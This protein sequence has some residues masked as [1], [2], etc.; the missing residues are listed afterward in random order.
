MPPTTSPSTKPRGYAHWRA[1]TL[2]GVHVLF[3]AHIVHWK[4]A[5]K[6]LA[7]LELNELMVTLELGVVTAGFAFMCLVFLSVLIFGRFFCS[8][9]CHI[10]A[11][12]D[13][14]QW[15]LDKLHIR[16]KPLRSR[17]LLWVPVGATL[18]MFLWPQ[19]SRLVAG[20]PLPDLRLHDEGQAWASF[21]TEDFWRNLPPVGMA[22]LTFF[23]VGFVVTLFLGSRSF[24]NYGCPYGALF[25]IAD[26]FTPGR[27]KRVSDCSSCGHCTAACS[28]GIEVHK[29]LERYGTV[30]SS[31]CL[32]D[33]DCIDACPS[34]AVGFGFTKP[35][36]FRK[37]DQGRP[38]KPAT[39]SWPEEFAG[40]AIF[41][42]G[43]FV[44]RGLYGRLPFLMSLSLGA[45]LAWFS[46][47]MWRMLREKH[48][49][50]GPWRLKKGGHW[51]RAG[52]FA[53]PIALLIWS[54][55][56]H[57]AWIRVLEVRAD[58][59]YEF[60]MEPELDATERILR[61]RSAAA[62]L[63]SLRATSPLPPRNTDRRI[64]LLHLTAA[65]PGGEV[66]LQR[67]VDANPDSAY[68]RLLLART[69]L[70]AGDDAAAR[71]ETERAIARGAF[72]HVEPTDG[73]TTDALLAELH[74]GCASDLIALERT[75][76]AL[77]HARAAV[78][79][80]PRNAA[81]RCETAS[82]LIATGQLE[83][84]IAELRTALEID[85]NYTLARERLSALGSP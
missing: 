48:A 11:L 43:L 67:A 63:R 33:L 22:L 83:A 41:L 61:A 27:I 6:T 12:Q 17:L 65:A 44:F 19:L 2:L 20:D 50:F 39:L 69:W 3:A 78:A 79:L 76:D 74:A 7:P 23:V 28:S 46:I 75:A 81:L 34:G 62:E 57:S 72:P 21:V 64:G 37:L 85:P 84:G 25:R 10:L 30:V 29:E 59:A 5:G 55:V 77:S 18:Y 15:I 70:L 13:G 68:L 26:R 42:I 56:G 4:L 60:A 51:T 52:K 66:P 32:R 14:S 58:N 35:T 31:S 71:A 47:A 45:L 9:G 40:A 82:L 36:I 80:R 16:P 73:A 38:R 53:L 49:A 1:W 24:C 8:W 54:Y